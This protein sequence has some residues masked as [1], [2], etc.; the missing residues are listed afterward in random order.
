[1][2]FLEKRRKVSRKNGVAVIWMEHGS[3]HGRLVHFVLK[4]RLLSTF[5]TKTTFQEKG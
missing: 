3:L 2:S 5:C 4:R 1:M